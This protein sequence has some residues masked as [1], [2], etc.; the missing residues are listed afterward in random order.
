LGIIDLLIL[1]A[2][3][4]IGYFINKE[5]DFI[6]SIIFLLFGFMTIAGVILGYKNGFKYFS[7]LKF[8]FYTIF[9]LVCSFISSLMLIL[10]VFSDLLH[11]SI[12][13][14][15]FVNMFFIS[16]YVRLN[17]WKDKVDYKPPYQN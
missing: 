3:I 15:P 11:G 12:F 16:L 6:S 9:L 7:E 4:P 13:L 14:F 10:L 8:Q 2:L 5:S 1:F 17:L